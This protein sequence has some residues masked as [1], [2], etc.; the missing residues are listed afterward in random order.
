MRIVAGAALALSLATPAL[1]W[2][3]AGH[4]ITATIAQIHL[5]PSAEKEICNILPAH[6]NCRLSS[7]AAWA[8][9]IRGLPQFR[10]TAGL[11][12]INP[13]AD[14][15]P[16]TCYFGQAGWKT[17]QNILQGIVN[18]TRGVDSLQGTQR[19]YALRFLVHFIGDI[20]MPLHLTGR[21]RGGNQDRVR[22]DGRITNLHSLWDGL[23]IAQRI[24]NLPNYTHPL[25]THQ[26]PSAP[27]EEIIRNRQIESALHGAIYDPYVRWIVLEGI[28]GWWSDEIEE[29]STCPQLS[30]GARGSLTHTAADSLGGLVDAHLEFNH[31]S[32]QAIFSPSAPLASPPFTDPTDVPVCPY[33]WAAPIHKLNC[34]FIWPAN[35]TSPHDPD[36]PGRTPAKDLIEL[37]TPEY[38]GRIRREKVVE[39]LMALGGIRLAAVLNELLASEEDKLKHGVIPML[40]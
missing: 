4:E 37:D 27:P 20:H 12:Y 16:E 15:P 30:E 8:D 23:L 11:H 34:D 38:M 21:D 19:D 5:L 17:D 36:H 1:S 31:A 40:F 29:W 3:A 10:W 39:H 22:Y 14:W 6:F 25:P 9:K 26:T 2:G 33:H 35:L 32:Q 24:R 18:V 7:I 13:T 28:Y